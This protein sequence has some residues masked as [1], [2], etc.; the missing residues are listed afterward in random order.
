MIQEAPEKQ[1]KLQEDLDSLSKW[2]GIIILIICGIIFLVNVLWLDTDIK[3]AFLTAI[4]LSV[5]AIPEG[6]PAVVTIALGIGVK[7]LLKK[8][9]LIKKLG[10][11]ETL[12]AVNIVCT[13]KTGTLTQNEMTVVKAYTNETIYELK[14]IGYKVK[15]GNELTEESPNL[16]WLFKIGVLCNTSKLSE[17]HEP[18]GDPTEVAHLVS[19]EK[20]HNKIHE[21]RSAEKLDE[22]PFDSERKLM[23]VVIKEKKSDYLLV[24]GAPEE[25]LK[26]CDYILK[27]GTITPLTETD[28]KTIQKQNQEFAENALRVLGFAYKEITSTTEKSE[29]NL[30]FV[31]LQAMIDPPRLEVKDAVQTCK[32]A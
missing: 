32:E 1:T 17:K 16:E 23:S 24:K 5:A 6:L 20:Y 14:G 13:D 21:W 25:I 11:V 31:G 12:G 26:N 4:A 18:I 8:Q 30:I 2:L 9:S 3:E 10:S 15:K 28:K 19:G 29:D 22:N 7:K 27:D